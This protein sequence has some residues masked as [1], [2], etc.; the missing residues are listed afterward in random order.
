MPD[1]PDHLKVMAWADNNCYGELESDGATVS[2]SKICGKA[3]I[4]AKTKLPDFI[5]LFGNKLKVQP[6][7]MA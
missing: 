6:T 5:S 2:Y 7:L 3:V 1:M 4:K